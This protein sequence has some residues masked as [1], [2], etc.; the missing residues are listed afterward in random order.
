M[1]AKS[2]RRS[3]RSPVQPET[4]SPEGISSCLTA[5]TTTS[6]TASSMVDEVTLRLAGLRP[7]RVYQAVVK[8]RDRTAPWAVAVNEDPEL[9]LTQALSIATRGPEARL[10]ESVTRFFQRKQEA[11]DHGAKLKKDFDVIE[12]VLVEFEPYLGYVAVAY[13]DKHASIESAQLQFGLLAE[14]RYLEED[15]TPARVRRRV[16]EGSKT[17]QK[18]AGGGLSGGRGKGNLPGT[19][20]RA[21]SGKKSG[22]SLPPAGSVPSPEEMEEMTKSA[23][24]RLHKELYGKQPNNKLSHQEIVQL[25]LS[26]ASPEETDE[27]LDGSE[28]L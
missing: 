17:P 1:P 7:R 3:R 9:A 11:V 23:L 21:P 27:D 6:D 12:E 13:I 28:L 19:R 8:F 25:I 22:G 18:L 2:H 14:V 20:E 16:P 26:K 10:K 5:L 15:D 24:I 4:P